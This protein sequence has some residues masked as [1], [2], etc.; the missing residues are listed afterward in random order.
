MAYS[1]NF[2]NSANVLHFSSNPYNGHR[3]CSHITHSHGRSRETCTIPVS[4]QCCLTSFHAKHYKRQVT[5][6]FRSVSGISLF[7]TLLSHYCT[8]LSDRWVGYHY[9]VHCSVAVRLLYI[10]VRSVSGISLF[11]T[12]F[13]RC[14]IIV[15]CCQIG[16][17]D[18]IIVHCCQIL[19]WDIIN[20]HCCQI[21]EWDII[22]VNCS[23]CHRPQSWAVT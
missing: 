10:A 15:H 6:L 13:C 23:L 9:F 21:L 16:E 22:I 1:I 19:E 12:L 3:T 8:L 11:C 2:V 20:V 17:W 7:C 14:Q 18:I 4:K 5:T